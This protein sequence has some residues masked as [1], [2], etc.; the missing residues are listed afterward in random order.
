MA[1]ATLRELRV[2]RE[3]DEGL[4]SLPKTCVPVNERGDERSGRFLV[5]FGVVRLLELCFVGIVQKKNF[6][7]HYGAVDSADLP[8]VNGFTP[9][10]VT[11][12]LVNWALIVRTNKT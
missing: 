11:V 9:S 7:V 8:F 5:S 3:L 4:R 1:L 10:L 6:N 12:P 2:L